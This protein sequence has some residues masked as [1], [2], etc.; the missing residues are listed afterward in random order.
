VNKFLLLKY[1]KQSPEIKMDKNNRWVIFSEILPWEELISI[2]SK[3]M[4]DLGRPA[5]DAHIARQAAS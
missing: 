3:S 1:I 5:I 2:Y 4:S